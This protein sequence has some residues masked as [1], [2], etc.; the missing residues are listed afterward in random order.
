MW[1]PHKELK[2]TKQKPN[3]KGKQRGQN[4]LRR[5]IF[6]FEFFFLLSSFLDSRVSDRHNS[7]G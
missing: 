5:K 3:Q 2:K 4:G 1:V 7:S 6:F